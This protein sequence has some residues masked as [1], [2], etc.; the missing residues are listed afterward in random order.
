[1]ASPVAGPI[2]PTFRACSP[3]P[4]A[5]SYRGLFGDVDAL[6]APMPGKRYIEV[7]STVRLYY[8]APVRPSLGISP[9][10]AAG[11]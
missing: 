5:S 1:M 6:E 10:K 8:A 7:V 11:R 9:A 2:G 3:S 4:A